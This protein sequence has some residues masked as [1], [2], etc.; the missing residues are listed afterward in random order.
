MP[1]SLVGRRGEGGGV[2]AFLFD[3]GVGGCRVWLGVRSQVFLKH[4]PAVRSKV[5]SKLIFASLCVILRSRVKRENVG[6][7]YSRGARSRPSCGWWGRGGRRSGG[8]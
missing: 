4:T 8:N 1:R 6:A 7:C 5:W 3:S 2:V